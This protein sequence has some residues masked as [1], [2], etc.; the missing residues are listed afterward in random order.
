MF[1]EKV[2]F[3]KINY[4]VIFFLLYCFVCLFF[5]FSK[6]SFIKTRRNDYF[7]NRI[8]YF[9]IH[10]TAETIKSLQ[11]TND[12]LKRQTFF[13]KIEL[14]RI[15]EKGKYGRVLDVR[16]RMQPPA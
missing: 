10:I 11:Y 2:F 12:P 3:L 6:P 7:S 15:C 13:E 14:K 4:S 9:D 1:S 5:N 16:V 8:C